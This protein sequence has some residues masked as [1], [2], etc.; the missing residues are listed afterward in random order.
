MVGIV[1]AALCCVALIWGIWVSLSRVYGTGGL[2]QIMQSTTRVSAM[3]FGIVIGAQLFS[4]VFRGLGGD[5]LVHGFLTS[6]PG[7]TIGAMVM[8]ICLTLI[9]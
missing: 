1:V 6:L 8:G 9:V 7:G 2:H 3:V 5:D 4:S